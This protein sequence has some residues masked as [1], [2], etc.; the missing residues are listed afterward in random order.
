MIGP[1]QGIALIL[2]LLNPYLQVVDCFEQKLVLLVFG[3]GWVLGCLLEEFFGAV[4]LLDFFDQ[5][6]QVFGSLGEGIDHLAFAVDFRLDKL[7]DN[8]EQ[9]LAEP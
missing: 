9:C 4:V 3:L 1:V 8:R 2:K 6:N 7:F 5:L